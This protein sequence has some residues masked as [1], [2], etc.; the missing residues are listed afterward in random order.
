MNIWMIFMEPA[1]ASRR[2]EFKISNFRVIICQ[3]IPS[4][5]LDEIPTMPS[6]K[7]DKKCAVKYCQNFALYDKKCSSS[8]VSGKACER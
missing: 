6:P 1:V 3:L 7:L 4:V 2:F 5:S 8:R